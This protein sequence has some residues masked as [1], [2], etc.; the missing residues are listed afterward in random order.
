MT[1]TEQRLARRGIGAA[2]VMVTIV[3]AAMRYLGHG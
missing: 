3:L 1:E 2:V